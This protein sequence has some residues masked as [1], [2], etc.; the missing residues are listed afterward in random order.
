MTRT[1]WRIRHAVL[2]AAPLLALAIW[3]VS[4]RENLTKAT[5]NVQVTVEDDLFGGV[6][7]ETRQVP[8]PV[9]GYYLGLYDA[10]VPVALGALLLGV[11][12]PLVRRWRR[13]DQP[14]EAQ[15]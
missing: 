13:Q 10:V 5:K 4:G 12:P 3:S 1:G 9:F 8:G 6:I 15:P 14:K 2:A 7:T 11:V